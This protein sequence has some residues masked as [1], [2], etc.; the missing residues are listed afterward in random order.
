MPDMKTDD[1]QFN[2]HLYKMDEYA[3]ECRDKG[4]PLEDFLIKQLGLDNETVKQLA[5]TWLVNSGSSR[6]PR[7]RSVADSIV[8]ILITPV[9]LLILLSFVGASFSPDMSLPGMLV[10]VGFAL[11]ACFIWVCVAY[12]KNKSIPFPYENFFKTAFLLIVVI[13]GLGGLIFF[14]S[15]LETYTIIFGACGFIAIFSFVIGKFFSKNEN[16]S[17][18]AN[19]LGVILLVIYFIGRLWY[20]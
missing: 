1:P 6:S 20:W 13:I 2:E 16:I 3:Q 5:K 15:T 7:K 10:S 17:K 14:S 19:V 9:I 4:I 8:L 12:G 18:V 11:F